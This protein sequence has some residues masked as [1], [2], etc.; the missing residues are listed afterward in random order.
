MSSIVAEK[1]ATKNVHIYKCMLN[2]Y[3][4]PKKSPNRK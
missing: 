2:V 1:N 4:N 3:K